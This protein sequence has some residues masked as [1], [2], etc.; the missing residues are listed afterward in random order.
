VEVL[1]AVIY[2]AFVS[3]RSCLNL[4]SLVA[5]FNGSDDPAEPINF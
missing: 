4:A 1:A 5:V 2:L 3:A